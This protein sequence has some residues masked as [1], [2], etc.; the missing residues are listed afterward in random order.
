[1]LNPPRWASRGGLSKAGNNAT[2]HGH[3]H[4]ASARWLQ[5]AQPR[6]SGGRESQGLC[7]TAQSPV[8]CSG[9]EQC[10]LPLPASSGPHPGLCGGEGQVFVPQQGDGVVLRSKTPSPVSSSPSW[11]PRSLPFVGMGGP[12]QTRC[13]CCKQ[14][15]G[16][17]STSFSTGFE[18]GF[19]KCESCKSQD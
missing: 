8:L 10:F 16:G 2:C 13:D 14:P 19:A 17:F 15:F 3:C 9:W 5:A 1:M 4:G 18:L 6:C 7:A 11:P 12:M